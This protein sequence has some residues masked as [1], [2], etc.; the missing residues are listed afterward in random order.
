MTS[1]GITVV[2]AARLATDAVRDSTEST[3]AK[4]V[5]DRVLEMLVGQREVGM[6]SIEAEQN[7]TEV[8]GNLVRLLRGA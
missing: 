6:G 8:I 5:F 3:A 1:F 2:R 4:I 7:D